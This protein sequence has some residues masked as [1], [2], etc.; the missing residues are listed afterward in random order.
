MPKLYIGNTYGT[1][2]INNISM[3]N[4]IYPVGSYYLTTDTTSTNPDLLKMMPKTTWQK[5]GNNVSITLTGETI[6]A[7]I[8]KRTA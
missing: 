7:N 6:T 2:V 4:K 5:V 1:P 3:L 8:W